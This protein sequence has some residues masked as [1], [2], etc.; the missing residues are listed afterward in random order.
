MTLTLPSTI[1][2]GETGTN[3]AG[4]NKR[5]MKTLT[6]NE[7]WLTWGVDK[8]KAGQTGF[9]CKI[10]SDA[11]LKDDAN[12][13]SHFGWQQGYA[14]HSGGTVGIGIAPE[15]NPYLMLCVKDS[16][17]D[18]ISS[19]AAAVRSLKGWLAAQYAAGTPVQIAY[20]LAAPVP[21]T[22]TGGAI[23][24]LSGTNTILTDADALTVT[25]RAD[26]IH[27]IQQLQAA[28]TASAQAI[29]DVE[30]AVTDI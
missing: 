21:F 8:T 4:Q 29:A 12:I 5:K 6:G 10:L 9:F 11:A 28:S 19:N 23:K 14:V 13:A 25:G 24:A 26:P 2:G 22:V 16:L 18:D 30:R 1:Y 17:L 20:K 3:G 27:I 15:A 7:D